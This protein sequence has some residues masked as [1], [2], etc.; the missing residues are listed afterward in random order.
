MNTCGECEFF[1]IVEGDKGECRENRIERHVTP[2]ELQ[3]GKKEITNG[4]PETHSSEQAC[5]QF[6]QAN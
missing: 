4:W 5:G 1:H 6:S 2:V 3:S